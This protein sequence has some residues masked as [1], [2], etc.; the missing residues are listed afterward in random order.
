MRSSY[1]AIIRWIGYIHDREGCS[2]SE[3]LGPLEYRDI[4]FSYPY[5]VNGMSREASKWG[6]NRFEIF[7]GDLTL[8]I[9]TYVQNIGRASSINQHPGYH[10]V[11]YCGANHQRIVVG[12]EE[13]PFGP[14]Q[15]H[16]TGTS[17]SI[18][19]S[20][21]SKVDFRRY[22]GVVLVVFTILFKVPSMRRG[23][24]SLWTWEKLFVFYLSIDPSH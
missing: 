11:G 16:S 9:G 23:L 14:S 4:H 20:P 17:L 21:P 8:V 13:I 22:R 12:S 6:S 24:N 5:G 15:I 7:S 10:K 19:L 2:Y 1:E 3:N 18:L